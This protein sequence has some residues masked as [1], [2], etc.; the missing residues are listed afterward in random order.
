MFNSKYKKEAL[1]NLKDAGK[2][3]DVKYEIL[4]LFLDWIL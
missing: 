3:Y 1:D 2:R 4:T